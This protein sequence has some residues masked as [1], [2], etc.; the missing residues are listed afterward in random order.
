MTQP[1]MKSPDSI[2]SHLAGLFSAMLLAAGITAW[3]AEAPVAPVTVP[4]EDDNHQH[5]RQESR[6]EQIVDRLLG[7]D[8]VE[9]QR[10]RRREQQA[11]AAG[12]RDEPEIEALVV[13]GLR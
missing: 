4:R 10:Q 6:F 1:N 9:N 2:L 12:R 7:D 11:E 3:S 5:A 13:T 8:A